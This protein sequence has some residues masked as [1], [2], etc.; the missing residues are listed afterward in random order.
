[1]TTPKDF[2]FKY[3]KR[4]ENPLEKLRQ[5]EPYF[6]IRAQ[7][8]ISPEAIQA[9]AELLHRESNKALGEGKDELS[10]SLMKQALGCQAVARAFM[11][12]QDANRQF[13]KL[14]D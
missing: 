11:D 4:G 12:W 9:Y 3:D 13:V 10:N 6:F 14:P 2:M 7:D 8:K 1:M 5:G